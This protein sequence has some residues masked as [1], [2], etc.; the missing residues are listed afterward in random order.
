MCCALAANY[1]S[2]SIGKTP[3]R[4]DITKTS[5]R[6]TNRLARTAEQHLSAAT[7][8]ENRNITWKMLVGFDRDPM[9][10]RTQRGDDR[11]IACDLVFPNAPSPRIPKD[12]LATTLR[13]NARTFYMIERQSPRIGRL[14]FYR[15]LAIML[16]GL[17]NPS[18]FSLP[19][20]FSSIQIIACA[21]Q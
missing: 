5:A 6:R 7:D 14:V 18:S 3:T 21:L 12:R 16:S 4:P 1:G 11:A 10:D 20:S 13:I 2:N 15:R 9:S 8:C 19:I 17:T